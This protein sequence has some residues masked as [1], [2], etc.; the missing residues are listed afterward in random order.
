MFT[1][2]PRGAGP[3]RPGHR[4]LS[5]ESGGKERAGGFTPGAP[6]RGLMAAEGCT[7]RASTG[8][9]SNAPEALAVTSQALPRLGW[10]ASI[11]R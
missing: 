10:H 4:F 11:T 2:R 3:A 8:R 7:D 9:S 1:T 5:K 6:K